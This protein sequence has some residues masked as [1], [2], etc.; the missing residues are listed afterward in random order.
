MPDENPPLF[1]PEQTPPV[2]SPSNEPV[3]TPSPVPETSRLEKI[4]AV[5]AKVGAKFK[6][7]RGRPTKS[8]APKKS[9][10]LI[11][12][13]GTVTP[14]AA[15]PAL[16]ATVPL[17]DSSPDA[18]ILHRAIISGCKGFLGGLR[19]CVGIYGELAG[20]ERK[21]VS[22]LCE[23]AKPEAELLAD[24]SEALEAVLRK[25]NVQTQYA[26]EIALAVAGAR[27]GAPY[28]LILWEI[29]KEIARKRE[30]ERASLAKGG[31][32]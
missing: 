24:F 23:R 2:E 27:L 18:A 29:R 32:A 10:V 17:A 25:Y 13:D 26:P 14:A 3:P 9:D 11:S 15:Q 22:D 30:A 8:G 20:L 4:R 6:V 31:A 7:G 16:A 21:F 12:P 1:P 19:D 28:A 5:A